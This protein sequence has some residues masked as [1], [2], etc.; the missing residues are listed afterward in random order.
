MDGGPLLRVAQRAPFTRSLARIF[1]HGEN[2]PLFELRDPF[3]RPW[4]AFGRR[5]RLHL[6]HGDANLCDWALVLRAGATALVLE[7]VE[8]IPDAD[9]PELARPLEALRQ[10]ADDPALA[11]E[12]ELADGSFASALEIQRRTLA[13]VRRVLAADPAPALWKARVLAM[14][15]ETLALLASDPAAL[16]D[17]V[18]WLAKR[19]LL[20]GVL[21]DPAD[22]RALEARGAA[23][24]DAPPAAAG[25]DER[26]RR[27]GWRALR[28]DFA[29]HELSA[30]GEQ[31]RLEAAGGVVR[32]ASDEA[33]ARALRE[34]PADTRAAARARAIRDA[35]AR[36]VSG[37]AS[38]H[39]ARIG[40]FAWRFFTDP[41]APRD[42]FRL[43]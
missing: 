24:L 42:T 21:P 1:T 39:R 32:L 12:L 36:G 2:R 41:L 7:A 11:R 17:R 4:S 14:W 22:R 10:V 29:Y 40:P 18:D 15:E 30:R 28:V 38:W 33:V 35:R 16:A 31:R 9:W 8:T 6:L 37:G 27:L 25:P 13:L 20:H 34:A 5:R 26:L 3:F 19:K 23:L 43:G